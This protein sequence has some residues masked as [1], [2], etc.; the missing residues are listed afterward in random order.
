MTARTPEDVDRL[1]AEFYGSYDAEMYRVAQ[2]VMRGDHA[3]LESGIIDPIEDL[4]TAAAR[5]TTVPAR[6][7]AQP[8]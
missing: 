6:E 3:W 1:F 4:A 2:A 8:V 7:M 5:T